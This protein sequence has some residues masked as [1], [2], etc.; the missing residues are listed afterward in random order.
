MLGAFKLTNLRAYLIVVLVLLYAFVLLCG[1]DI[2]YHVIQASQSL[3]L[4]NTA[5]IRHH[6]LVI[7]LHCLSIQ[8]HLI[9]FNCISPLHHI[10]DLLRHVLI[11]EC[12]HHG[13][14][15]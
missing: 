10:I 3:I 12:W 11:T 7:S 5:P 14:W 2:R 8:A 4:T 9:F 1:N 6:P 13:N 15:Y